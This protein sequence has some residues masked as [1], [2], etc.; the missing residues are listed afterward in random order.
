MTSMFY[1][2]R[3]TVETTA[4]MPSL[5]ISRILS[6]LGISKAWYYRHLDFNPIIDKRFNPFEVND[7]ELRVLKYRYDH[8]RMR[9][10]FL[11]YSMIDKEIA[12]LSPSEV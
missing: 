11:A 9:F 6:I 1:E 4:A 2:I 7:E 8:P 3:K 12:Y 5:P 10:R